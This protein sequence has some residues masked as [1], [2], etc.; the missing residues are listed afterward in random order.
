[1]QKNLRLTFEG[2]Y[3]LCLVEGGAEMEIVDTLVD[4][5]CLPFSR[6]DLVGRKVHRRMTAADVQEKFLSL[7]YAR[8]L[9]ILRILDSRQE[10][11]RLDRLFRD[12]FDVV[13]LT[14]RPE[15][16]ILLIL[17]NGD[18]EEFCKVKSRMKPS[19]FCRLKY[20]YRKNQGEFISFFKDVDE[21][22]EVLH[23]YSAITSDK[24]TLYDLI[25]R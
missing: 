16:E 4:T 5:G 25:A 19:V 24:Q 14:T 10:G 13:T 23:R 1:M 11:F 18:Y 12:R 8:P 21:L 9:V 20:G 15:I 3:V 7:D 22:V 2:K 17:K 6:E